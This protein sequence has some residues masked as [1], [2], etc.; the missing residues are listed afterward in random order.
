MIKSILSR[1]TFTE[2]FRFLCKNAI[3][4][5]IIAYNDA[6]WVKVF[7]EFL[8]LFNLNDDDSKL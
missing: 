7:K 2:T 4:V 5:I 8:T 1:K 3:D 6:F